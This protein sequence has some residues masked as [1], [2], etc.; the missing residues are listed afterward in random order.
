VKERERRKGD[1]QSCGKAAG[2]RAHL[3]TQQSFGLADLAG[4]ECLDAVGGEGGHEAAKPE[5]VIHRH[6]VN[7]FLSAEQK[8]DVEDLLQAL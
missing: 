8:G 5:G 4:S 7:S 6:A 2:E 3:Y 1:S